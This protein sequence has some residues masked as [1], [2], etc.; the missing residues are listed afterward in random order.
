[1]FAENIHC[2]NGDIIVHFYRDF[3]ILSV[4]CKYLLSVWFSESL[5]SKRV[6]SERAFP[7][8]CYRN[9]GWAHSIDWSST[10]INDRDQYMISPK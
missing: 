3:K 6:E 7:S 2:R 4:Y 10:L 1:M 8:Q 5:S 9:D